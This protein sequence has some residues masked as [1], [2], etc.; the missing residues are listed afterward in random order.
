MERELARQ[1][2]VLRTAVLE[3]IQAAIEEFE[4]RH[5]E[6]FPTGRRRKLRPRYFDPETGAVWSGR[7]REPLWLRGKNREEFELKIDDIDGSHVR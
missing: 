3:D 1:R 5:E 6:I 2:E 7:G 4:F